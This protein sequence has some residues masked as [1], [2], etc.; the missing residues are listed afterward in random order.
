MSVWPST[1]HIVSREACEVLRAVVLLIAPKLASWR[2]CCCWLT[3]IPDCLMLATVA[4]NLLS[5]NDWWHLIV[6][7]LCRRPLVIVFLC[8]GGVHPVL[9]TSVVHRSSSHWWL[10]RHQMRRVVV[11]PYQITMWRSVLL[12]LLKLSI[13]TSLTSALILINCRRWSVLRLRH[14]FIHAVLITHSLA[15]RLLI[16]V[17][18]ASTLTKDL[19]RIVNR[20]VAR[21]VAHRRTT[22]PKG[23]WVSIVG[24][25]V[26]TSTQNTYIVRIHRRH[27]S[28][29]LRS[30]IW[31]LP[32]HKIVCSI[33][34]SS[35]A[36]STLSFFS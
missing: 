12:I 31:T 6:L 33:F 21:L 15:S 7:S 17:R 3:V 34:E 4:S 19:I 14:E 20:I 27:L 1:R 30:S 29:L 36:T 25:V 16:Y 18:G 35:T 11:L 13:E 10:R 26:T 23:P 8:L 28:M 9:P 2:R 5:G 22:R 32:M 24:V